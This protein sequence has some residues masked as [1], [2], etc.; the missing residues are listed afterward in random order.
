MGNQESAVLHEPLATA[1]SEIRLLVLWPSSVRDDDVRAS[2]HIASLDDAPDFE[3]LS[4]VWGD[5]SVRTAI[6]VNNETMLVTTNLG[7]CLRRLRSPSQPRVLWVDAICINQNDIAE[8]NIQVLL[9]RRIYVDATSV[10]VWL[11]EG[12]KNIELALSWAQVYIEN[13]SSSPLARYWQYLESQTERTK[14]VSEERRGAL[15][16]A[17]LGYQ[18]LF[19]LEYWTRMWTFQEF[20]LPFKDPACVYGFHIVTASTLVGHSWKALVESSRKLLRIKHLKYLYDVDVIKRWIASI[21]QEQQ[22][23]PI[24]SL[25]IPGLIEV[26]ECARSLFSLPPNDKASID[27]QFLASSAEFKLHETARAVIANIRAIRNYRYNQELEFIDLLRFTVGR[28]SF[29][30]RDRFYGVYGLAPEIQQKFP[31]DYAKTPEQVCLEVTTYLINCG[32]YKLLH[33]VFGLREHRLSNNSLPSWVPN[34]NETACRCKHQHYTVI[35]IA[36]SLPQRT[37]KLPYYKLSEDNITLHLSGRTLGYCDVIWL[38][39]SNVPDIIK[40]I[41]GT[42]FYPSIIRVSECSD[43]IRN[44]ARSCVASNSKSPDFTTD[45]ILEAYKTAWQEMA[46][47]DGV[48]WLA[49]VHIYD[50]CVQMVLFCAS[51]LVGKKLFRVSNGHFG[52]GGADVE[53]GDLVT[54]PVVGGPLVLRRGYKIAETESKRFYRLVGAA[55]MGAYSD[56]EC[57]DREL[58]AELFAQVPMEFLIH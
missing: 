52:I 32:K 8:K 4:Y 16:N 40:R 31:E 1:R 47:L 57:M 26:F 38:F 29:D 2:L 48:E 58:V 9:M 55:Y 22:V 21:C 35:N 15:N 24:N 10:V 12:N 14:I 44:L 28:E 46:T 19:G 7:A 6:T 39:E 42:L 27:N 13:E 3:A 30:L 25:D 49:K 36:P 17:L 20:C 56:G 18:D 23:G 33:E 45:Q 37:E 50:P 41:A 53:D 51:E 5:Q 54:L 11:G 34:F 43:P